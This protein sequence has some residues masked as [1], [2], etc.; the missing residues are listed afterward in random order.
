NLNDEQLRIFEELLEM[1]D[2]DLL[3]SILG[4]KNVES[5]EWKELIK[6]IRKTWNK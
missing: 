6:L 1:D 4:K 2:L 5:E 3:E